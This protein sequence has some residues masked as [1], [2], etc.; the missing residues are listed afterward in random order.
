MPDPASTDSNFERTFSDLAYARM[1][2]KAPTLLNYLLGFQL[3]DKND[4]DTH[5]VGVFGFKV[6]KEYIYCPVF[7]ING[8]LKGH[9]LMYLKSQ[10]SFVPLLEEWV[11]YVL[12]RRPRLL[13]EVNQTPRDR[14]GLRQPDFD[15][16]A[17]APYMGSKYASISHSFNEVCKTMAERNPEMLP[18]MDVFT[19]GPRDEKFACLN[20]TFTIPGAIKKLGKQ[21]AI[22]LV[23]NMK[24]DHKFAESIL[25]FYN[26]EDII[27]AAST[28]F[29]GKE[30]KVADVAAID[31][32]KS[33]EDLD[34]MPGRK[35]GDTI[36]KAVVITRGDDGSNTK[37]DLSEAEKE[38]LL[39]EQ[40]IVKDPRTDDQRSRL[41][42]SQMAVTLNSPD[43]TGFY[44]ALTPSGETKKVLILHPTWRAG[45]NSNQQP[46]SIL[47]IDP[48]S[49]RYGN[50]SNADVLT[51]KWLGQPEFDSF[52]KGL[53]SPKSV[54]IDDYFVIIA[55][56]GGS[57]N[58]MQVNSTITHSDGRTELKVYG[59]N[60]PAP[61]SDLM[62]QH[63]QVGGL[64]PVG[65]PDT[66]RV[67]TVL[68]TEREAT[69]PRVVGKTL[70]V[71]KGF[72]AYVLKSSGRKERRPARY[73]GPGDAEFGLG[74]WNDVLINLKTAADNNGG[75]A[76]L[77]MYNDGIGYV[78][79]V[80]GKRGNSL[81]KISALRFL[82]EGQG[83][84]QDDA[85]LIIKEASSRA[86]TTYWVKYAY[87]E[88]PMQAQFNEP[89]YGDEYGIR[90]KMQYPSLELQNLG[91]NQDAAG[92]NALYR[93]DRAVD[94]DAKNYAS[95]ASNMGQKEVLDTSVIS[96]LVKT[97]DTDTAVDSY[98]PD[99]LLG[100]D[101]IGRVLFTYY[102]KTDKFKER[103]VPVD[104]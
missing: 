27:N 6:G 35:G 51:S 78:P 9:E 95:T 30:V 7:F 61:S 41:Y 63:S 43:K 49:K 57:T 22:T 29:E 82:I 86:K 68:L 83:L 103:C 64:A 69:E 31:G 96:G 46:P 98:I 84:G 66:G 80:N 19:V 76:L 24:K 101:R 50:F 28:A 67:D 92:A 11:N 23:S 74:S 37:Q 25:R 36:P 18:F 4:D 16:F 12:N 54:G 13:G 32:F 47:V 55:P 33:A 90:A 38:K 100:L 3:I 39:K 45:F 62:T 26:M 17:R 94:D 14:M 48:E 88:P 20:E 91:A 53:P 15:L 52:F 40:Y 58:V 44:E 59:Y 93:D 89:Q 56:N 102:W 5:A 1:R 73:D 87:G 85:E 97:Q 77:Q 71:P 10:D 65:Y 21:A 99:L 72:K 60:S 104:R 8:E 42:R 70:F 34:S 79:T 81:T 2:D 75:V